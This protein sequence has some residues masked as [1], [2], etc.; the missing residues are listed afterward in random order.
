MVGGI[1]GAGTSAY[2]TQVRQMMANSSTVS[3][4]SDQIAATGYQSASKTRV[5]SLDQAFG[6]M[7]TNG[8]GTISKEELKKAKTTMEG[9][10][11]DALANFQSGSTASLMSLLQGSDQVFSQMD[12]NSD[13]AISKEELLQGATGTGGTSSPLSATQSATQSLLSQSKNMLQQAVN[14]YRQVMDTGKTGAAMGRV[15]LTG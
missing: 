10:I 8:D 5:L 13:G 7:D 6:K 14:Q 15:L 4:G 9:Q 11:T 12:A 1:S 3:G 2:L